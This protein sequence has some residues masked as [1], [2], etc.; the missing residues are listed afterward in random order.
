MDRFENIWLSSEE[1]IKNYQ[2]IKKQKQLLKKI[3]TINAGDKY[4]DFPRMM[5]NGF[6]FPVIFDNIGRLIISDNNIQFFVSKNYNSQQY[7]GINNR[8]NIVISYGQISH[9]ELI[10]FNT[11]FIRYFENIWIKILFVENSMNKNLLLSFSGKGFIMK[12]IRRQ[13]TELYDKIRSK[14]TSHNNA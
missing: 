9:I 12:K 8:D 7:S 3:D 2:E 11:A 1:H 14:I 5:V 4:F 13:N 10:R 6:V